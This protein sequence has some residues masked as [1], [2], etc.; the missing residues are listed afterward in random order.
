MENRVSYVVV[1]IFVFVL[2]ILS[3]VAI[4][5]LGKYAQNEAFSYYRVVTK[6]SV[7]GL[8]KNA[9]VK[10]RGVSVGE[11]KDIYINTKNSEEVI[12][13]IKVKEKTPIKE[14]T[15]ALINLQ[16]ITGL[17]YIELAGGSNESPLLKTDNKNPAIIYTK[18]SMLQRVDDTLSE[19]SRKTMVVLQKT[20]KVMSEKN[21]K[22]FEEILA[23]LSKATNT[24]NE[25]LLMINKK[26][27]EYD[28][29]IKGAI[30]TEKSAIK[31]FDKISQMANIWSV[32][33]DKTLA[34]MS[35]A[36]DTTSKVMLS[37]DKKL[38]DGSLDFDIIIRE[39]LLPVQND[40][41]DLRGLMI[42]IREWIDE[43]KDS[44]SDLFFKQSI[45]K[46]AP[47]E[48]EMQE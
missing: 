21:L 41:E 39:N 7:S 18:A 23:N 9:P 15:Y 26:E 6:E 12:I 38:K 37:L 2:A 24:L 28:L 1:G 11:V 34:K 4:L 43:L 42:D 19:I 22:N 46:I 13:L 47:N 20:Q 45:S 33:G 30:D 16:G 27:K 5:W 44:P 36:S 10:Y 31:A 14:D 40:L 32:S 29:V 8:N 48:K 25:T 3:V 35:N 17:S